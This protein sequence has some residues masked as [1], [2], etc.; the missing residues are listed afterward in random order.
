MANPD[1]RL[2]VYISDGLDFKFVACS[3]SFRLCLRYGFKKALVSYETK[4]LAI[5]P[6]NRKFFSS[7]T[8]LLFDL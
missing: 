4:D 2:M 3:T 1:Y 5:A 7:L 6:S 8:S